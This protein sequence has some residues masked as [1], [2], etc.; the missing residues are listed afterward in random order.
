M[1]DLG[2]EKDH[3]TLR[4]DKLV[5]TVLR[6]QGFHGSARDY[7]IGQMQ[8]GACEA[9]HLFSSGTSHNLAR[10]RVKMQWSKRQ[11]CANGQRHQPNFRMRRTSWRRSKD[12]FFASGLAY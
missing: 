7:Y 9:A 4:N 1:N 11:P 10:D 2:K 8:T 3:L 5:H 6:K 12:L